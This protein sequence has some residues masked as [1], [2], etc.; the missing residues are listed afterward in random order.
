MGFFSLFSVDKSSRI[1]AI[2]KQIE[3]H[4]FSTEVE[5]DNIP[6]AKRSPRFTKSQIE[7]NLRRIAHAKQV[8][9][10]YREEL[11]LLRNK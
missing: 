10:K 3:A 1:E 11:V 2:K 4:K 5:K 8:M 9:P 7:G 6:R